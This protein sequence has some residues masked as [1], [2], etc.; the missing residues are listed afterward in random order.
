MQS[1]CS[2]LLNIHAPVKEW[3]AEEGI[4]E[5]DIESRIREMSDNHMKQKTNNMTESIM[6]HVEKAMVLQ[7]LDTHWKEHLLNLDHLR[8]GISLR[9]FAQ[10]DPLNEYKAEAFGYFQDML[11][12]LKE[13]VT[14]TLSLIDIDPQKKSLSLMP[15]TNFSDTIAAQAPIENK[16]KQ[17]EKVTPFK[18]V[19]D[20]NDETTWGTVQRNAPCPC[21]SG[22]KYKHCH[23][24]ISDKRIAG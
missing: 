10:R 7:Q 8:Q 22:K 17:P 14:M 20:K 24:A 2:R 3:A 12:R 15:K 13:S 6:R 16:Q 18:H 4:A 1:E 23:G 5:E 19:F 11:A 21:G 9:A